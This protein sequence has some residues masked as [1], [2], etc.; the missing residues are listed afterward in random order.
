MDIQGNKL[1]K[2]D[3]EWAI[4]SIINNAKLNNK[5]LVAWR[6]IGGQKV[7]V[8]VNIRVIRKFRAELVMTPQNPRGKQ[9]LADLSS[10][11]DRLNFYLMDDMVLFQSKIKNKES[12]GDIT[13]T[14]PNMIAQIDRRKHLR[15]FLEEDNQVVINFVKETNFTSNPTQRF[16]K[17][18][19]DLSAGGL[20]FIISKSES[21]FF[22]IGD[23]IDGIKL[24]VDERDILINAEIVNIFN[25]EPNEVNKLNYRGQKICIKYTKIKPSGQKI[26]SEFVFKSIDFSSNVV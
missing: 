9:M 3:S 10:G 8:D 7:T 11:T 15:L 12:N 1:T 19:F 4:F 5:T 14:L 17:N 2:N 6:I 21:K 16:T 20:S 24:K 26:L 13:V 18:C 25:V 22:R 23:K